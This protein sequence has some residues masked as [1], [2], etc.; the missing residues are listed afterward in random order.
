MNRYADAGNF[1]GCVKAWNG[2]TNGLAERQSQL[3]RIQRVLQGAEWGAV[4]DVPTKPPD[5]PAP[6]AGPPDPIP[7]QTNPQ[8]PVLGGFFHA[9]INLFKRGSK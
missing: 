3:A 1:I 6:S 4:A 2:G 8:P 9:L 5:S 7:A